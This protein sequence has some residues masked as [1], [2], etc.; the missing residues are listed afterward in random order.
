LSSDDSGTPSFLIASETSLISVSVSLIFALT[1]T[2]YSSKASAGDRGAVSFFVES[3]AFRVGDR[4]EESAKDD[5][6]AGLSGGASPE[7][8]EEKERTGELGPRFRPA[9]ACAVEK[10]RVRRPPKE[11]KARRGWR[12][13][14]ARPNDDEE[15]E[16]EDEDEDASFYMAGS[17]SSCMSEKC[18]YDYL[19]W[20]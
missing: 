17:W 7:G 9:A 20:L 11:G 6:D 12:G 5:G 18:K 15:D 3:I 2:I 1:S 10:V 14:D 4:E 13:D 19:F 8:S 16:D